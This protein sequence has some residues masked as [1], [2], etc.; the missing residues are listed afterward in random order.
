MVPLA[1]LPA[2]MA[3]FD[4]SIAPL[5]VGNVFC[6]AKSELKYVQAALLDVCTI[7]SPTGP[8]RRAIRD[9]ENWV[10]RNDRGRLVRSLEDA[11]HR[12]WPA[13]T[14]GKSSVF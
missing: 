6:E 10:A 2:E 7:A 4:V 13:A 12:C 5:E 9:G 1:D 14:N 8:Y 11:M 3:R